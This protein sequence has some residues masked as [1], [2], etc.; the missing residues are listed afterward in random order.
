MLLK[1]SD[2]KEKTVPILRE[3]GVIYAGVFGSYARGEAHADSDVDLLVKTT[4]PISLLVFFDLA[5]KLEDA[6]GKKVDIVTEKSV[7]KRV[8]PFIMS[9]LKT[10]YEN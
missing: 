1:L 8:R 7:N 4:K 3:Y 9:D 2:I 5:D 10:I 6:L